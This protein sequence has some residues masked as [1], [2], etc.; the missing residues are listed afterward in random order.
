MHPT[1][2]PL[3]LNKYVGTTTS[4]SPGRESTRRHL[5]AP[6]SPRDRITRST[7]NLRSHLSPRE[8]SKTAEKSPPE[9]QSLDNCKIYRLSTLKAEHQDIVVN[10]IFLDLVVKRKGK[11]IEL[12]RKSPEMDSSSAKSFLTWYVTS[13][14]TPKGQSKFYRS[15]SK[16]LCD[17]DLG[18]NRVAKAIL[19]IINYP[20]VQKKTKKNIWK[21]LH[22][23]NHKTLEIAHDEQTS[24]G[25]GALNRETSILSELMKVTLEP[26]MQN[27]L[28][29]AT[30]RARLEL[31]ELPETVLNLK[32]SNYRSRDA[33]KL[34]RILNHLLEDTY[35]STNFLDRKAQLLFRK[36]FLNSGQVFEDE[37]VGREQ[38][39]GTYFLRLLSPTLIS[40]KEFS[41]CDDETTIKIQR[42]F[43]LASKLL[44]F[45]VLSEIIPAKLVSLPDPLQSL[46]KGKKY[47][48]RRDLITQ[49]IGNVVGI[50]PGDWTFRKRGT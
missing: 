11:C 21:F 27:S 9:S 48:K 46:F 25:N 1:V 36:L 10:P 42:S 6:L 34:E 29:C 33:R 19:G 30:K 15:L 22:D 16:S 41:E 31:I 39:I 43:V 5:L 37:S 28:T 47:K 23:F 35:E 2:P 3:N 8:K 7:R 13:M 4:V 32:K 38:I 18:F 14:Q 24:K 44:H 12:L 17:K 20:T 49:I 40:M 26:R 50:Y 45:T